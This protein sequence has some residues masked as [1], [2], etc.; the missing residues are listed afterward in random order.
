MGGPTSDPFI[1][2]F[3]FALWPRTYYRIGHFHGS[4]IK[5][6]PGRAACCP[7][8][9]SQNRC[10]PQEPVTKKSGRIEQHVIVFKNCP[11]QPG[12]NWRYD[13][14]RKN[15][16]A[17]PEL[18]FWHSLRVRYQNMHPEALIS[19]RKHIN[20][21]SQAATPSA[22]GGHAISGPGEGIRGNSCQSIPSCH[23]L[24]GVTPVPAK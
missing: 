18:R 3:Y 14:G 24:A 17:L 23:H 10:P 20:F 13:G 22:P 19:Y 5:A 1:T 11:R 9:A 2:D 7:V 12:W 4:S 21:P 15:P 6:I 8:K 16:V